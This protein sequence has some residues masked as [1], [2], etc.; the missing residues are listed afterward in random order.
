MIKEF[1]ICTNKNIIEIKYI[2]ACL[3]NNLLFKKIITS[4]NKFQNKIIFFI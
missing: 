3:L 2:Y 4:V 1:T